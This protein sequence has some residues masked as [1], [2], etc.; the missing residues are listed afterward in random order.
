MKTW[1]QWLPS[2]VLC[3]FFG[4]IFLLIAYPS[5]LVAQGGTMASLSGTV[6]DPTGAV[7]PNA[8][9]VL[10]NTETSDTR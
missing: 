2:A 3:A 6:T 8:V 1:E 9:V 4:F 5:A 10:K 7:I